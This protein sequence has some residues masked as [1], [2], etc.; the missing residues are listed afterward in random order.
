MNKPI[1]FAAAFLSVIGTTT[2]FA[3]SPVSPPFPSPVAMSV[4]SHINNT[5]RADQCRYDAN[6]TQYIAEAQ[7]DQAARDALAAAPG[8]IVR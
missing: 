6:P 1:L 4:C 8:A 2:A 7:R 3:Q 5:V